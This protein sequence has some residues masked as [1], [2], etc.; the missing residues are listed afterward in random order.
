MLGVIFIHRGFFP[1]YISS[2]SRFL[3]FQRPGTAECP[4]GPYECRSANQRLQSQYCLR[5]AAG[6]K[7]QSL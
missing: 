3:L 6:Y 5:K 1:Y 4:L 2:V 7:A